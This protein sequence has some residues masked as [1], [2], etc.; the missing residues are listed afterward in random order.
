MPYIYRYSVSRALTRLQ[1]H[2]MPLKSLLEAERISCRLVNHCCQVLQDIGVLSLLCIDI[3]NAL[4][5]DGNISHGG[6]PIV[7]GTRYILAV[8]IYAYSLLLPTDTNELSSVFTRRE[9]RKVSE[10]D[11]SSDAC[12]NC[13]GF[14]FGFGDVS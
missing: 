7:S 11:S 9:K 12:N 4:S 13:S 6:A 5:F 1:L 8:F 10:I 14:S 2:L 3:G